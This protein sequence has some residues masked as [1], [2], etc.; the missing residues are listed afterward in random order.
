MILPQCSRHNRCDSPRQRWRYMV[1][2]LGLGSAL[3]VG[4]SGESSGLATPTISTLSSPT[5]VATTIAEGDAFEFASD[6]T[7]ADF[8][9]DGMPLRADCG[10][11][12]E[13]F[14]VYA[15]GVSV[16]WESRI[17]V[18]DPALQAVGAYIDYGINTPQEYVRIWTDEQFES[19]A[20]DGTFAY[21][22]E[23]EL[24]DGIPAFWGTGSLYDPGT[25]GDYVSLED[26]HPTLNLSGDIL[27]LR[28]LSDVSLLESQMTVSPDG[29]LT[30]TFEPID[31]E[32]RNITRAVIT[33]PGEI[34]ES[35]GEVDGR[36]VAWEAPA[37]GS[38]LFVKSHGFDDEY[39]AI[40]RALHD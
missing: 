13:R 31:E 16:M 40:L 7:S 38:R 30:L 11:I 21:Y 27:Y 33:M 6:C 19:D 5:E 32:R 14:D 2:A 9:S 26:M 1:V 23:E 20:S 37:G 25:Y 36:T 3:L 22:S 29:A 15:T 10:I 34:I 35:N 28:G 39:V 18:A 12:E 8:D 24:S 4:C 17:F